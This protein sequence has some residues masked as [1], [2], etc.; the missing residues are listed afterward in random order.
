MKEAQRNLLV[1]AATAVVG[2][3]IIGLFLYARDS[4]WLL[5]LVGVAGVAA[6]VEYTNLT[7]KGRPAGERGGV[8]AI[9]TGLFLALYLRPD[10][11][12]AWSMAAVLAVGVLMVPRASEFPAAAHR[13]LAAGFGVFYVGGLL[14]ALP[15]LHR[16]V[17]REWVVLAIALTFANDTGAYFVGRAVGKHKLAPAISPGKTW[18]GAFG[19]L[20]ASLAVA[21]AVRATL[22][23]SLTAG[24]ALLIG[25]PAAI[26]GPTG[27]LL[28]SLLKR[29]VGAKD[30]GRLLPGH[31]GMLDRVDALLF[32]GAYVH[33]YS[34]LLR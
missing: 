7:L 34:T 18:E 5:G 10:Q 28:E 13:L 25:A 22:I 8:T 23:P 27:D 14:C 33:L 26:L 21:F 19:G 2:L 29:S 3:P 15:L 30:S 11:A 17:G 4:R 16:D 31:G 20:A 24:D 6:L 32:V 9:G 12:L 1:R